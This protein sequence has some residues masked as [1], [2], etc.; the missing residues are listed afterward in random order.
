MISIGGILFG[1]LFIVF[2]V[3]CVK[4]NYRVANSLRELTF[5]STLGGG[6]IYNGVKLLGIVSILFGLTIAFGLWQGL[7][8][9]VTDPFVN[10]FHK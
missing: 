2:G 6:D 3:S 4:W 5:L 9:L 1:L 8:G 7:L 10:M